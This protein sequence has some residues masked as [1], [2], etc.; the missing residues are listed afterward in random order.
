M[1]A[2]GCRREAEAADL[3]HGVCS[4]LPTVVDVQ[5]RLI[6]GFDG[7]GLRVLPSDH[8]EH[9]LMS[10]YV[11]QFL[12]CVGG[13]SPD[14]QRHP[15]ILREGMKEALMCWDLNWTGWGLILTSWGLS[16]LSWG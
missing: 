2:L 15:S 1:H 14:L 16:L 12:H 8:L 4:K 5:V 13:L 7:D 11:R 9:H 10:A 3:D 6:E